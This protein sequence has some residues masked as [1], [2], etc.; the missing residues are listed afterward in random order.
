MRRLQLQRSL[1]HR[2]LLLPRHLGEF[3][4]SARG[5]GDSRKAVDWNAVVEFTGKRTDYRHRGFDLRRKRCN[6]CFFGGGPG[7]GANRS[8]GDQY[9]EQR[10]QDVR[11]WF[12]ACMAFLLGG[13]V[14]DDANV[15]LRT[16]FSPEGSLKRA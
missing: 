3:G 6:G 14:D 8:R 7:G 9:D 1:L 15:R 16:A 10:G 13:D 4:A 12:V 5:H 2:E 11:V